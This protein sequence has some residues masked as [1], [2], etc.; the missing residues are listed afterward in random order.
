MKYAICNTRI[1]HLNSN[2]QCVHII[3]S[4]TKRRFWFLVT[5]AMACPLS[6]LVSNITKMLRLQSNVDGSDVIKGTSDL[7]LVAIQI[8]I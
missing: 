6:L 1:C 7:I 5:L 3:T 8:M 2:I 4:S